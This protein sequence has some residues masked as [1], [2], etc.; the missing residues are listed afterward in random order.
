MDVKRLQTNFKTRVRPDQLWRE[1]YASVIS[2][3]TNHVCY[4]Y[5]GGCKRRLYYISPIVRLL[6]VKNIHLILTRI[7][8]YRIGYLLLKVFYR[9]TTDTD[10]FGTRSGTKG[11]GKGSTITW[12]LIAHRRANF[13][14]RLT[15]KVHLGVFARAFNIFSISQIWI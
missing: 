7:K 13:A 2:Y 6:P 10:H 12:T 14:K 8:T 1:M 9:Y 5:G 11:G 15:T 4:L 3:N